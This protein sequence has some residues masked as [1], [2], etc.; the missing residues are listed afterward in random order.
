MSVAREVVSQLAGDRRWYSIG[1]LT[2]TLNRD[3]RALSRQ[4]DKLV[5]VTLKQRKFQHGFVYAHA[6]TQDDAE[7]V[8]VKMIPQLAIVSCGRK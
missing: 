3:K 8:F 4:V 6:E 2:V 5:G 1:A 7:I